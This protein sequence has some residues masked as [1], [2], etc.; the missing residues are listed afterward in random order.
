[1]FTVSEDTVA[2]AWRGAA[3]EFAGDDPG[4]SVTIAGGTMS[5]SH[6]G[7]LPRPG[8]SV[9]K[10]AVAVAV[11]ELGPEAAVATAAVADLPRSRWPSMLDTLAPTHRLTLVELAGIMLATSDNRTAEHL[12]RHLGR[13]RINATLRAHG[14]TDTRLAAGF[15]DEMLGPRG[16][17]NLATT[18]ECARLLTAIHRQARLRPVL[19][20]LRA[21]LNHTRIQL[22]LPDEVVVAH[23]TGTLRGVVN[24]IGIIESAAGPLTV[25]FLTDGQADPATTAADIGRCAQ[26]AYATWI[27]AS[28]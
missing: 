1:V 9:L 26:R 8:A 7:A 22:R 28:C 20:G 21:N 15:G 4:R 24:D 14:C 10:L 13:D 2:S 6:A 16:R 3:A 18:D 23:K 19:T 12:V 27:E 11:C 5:V 17:A 25:C